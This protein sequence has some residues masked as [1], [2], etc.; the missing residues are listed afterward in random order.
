MQKVALKSGALLLSLAL[1]AS[2][3][4]AADP[5]FPKAPSGNVTLQV[6]SWVPGLD[7]TVA[8]FTKQY[9]NISIKILNLGGGP[10]TYTKLQTAIK[11]GSGAPDVAQVEYG[12]L[13]AFADTG[14][15]AD[16][17]K[18]GANDYKKY[19]VP[20]TWGQVSP[21]SQAVYAIPQDTGPFA[22]VYRQDILKKYGVAVPKTWDEYAKAAATVNTK[23]KGAVKLG[24]FYATFAPW[25]MAL[26][27]AD[28]GQFF[29]RDGDGWIQTLNNSSSKKVLNYWYGLIKKGD[30]STV[31]AFSADY[32]NA[33]GAG[34][35]ASNM[36]AAWG[37]GGYAGSLKDKSAGLWRV[38][39]IPQWTAGGKVASGNWGGSSNVVTTQSKNPEAA[40]LFA[41]WL[42]LSTPAITA[43]WNNGGLF[44][45]SDAGLSL[46]ALANKTKN[47][48]K[49]F[50][51]QDISAVYAQA[52]RGVNVNFQWAPWFPFV[53]DNFNKQMDKMLKGQLTPDQALDAWQAESLAEAKKGGF[54]VK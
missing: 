46:S 30:I 2:T 7:K 42:N 8:A 20:W 28:G 47:P 50:G 23:S 39:P 53:N 26:A 9:P 44:P 13:P 35:I 45:A 5:A 15:I 40:T 54:T 22:M 1:A 36:E 18:Y 6:W 29:K 43:N 38:A 51:G 12:F 16:L 24:N 17:S 14:G 33:A 37:P 52:S 27:W 11:A 34:K 25:F 10:Q 3:A 4:H 49:F 19:F 32:W 41:L 21:D 31:G 48:S